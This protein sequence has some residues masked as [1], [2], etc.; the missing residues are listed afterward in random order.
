[1][2]LNK[3][4][5]ISLLFFEV[6][7]ASLRWKFYGW[8]IMEVMECEGASKRNDMEEP[9]DEENQNYEDKKNTFADGD[10]LVMTTT[11]WKFLNDVRGI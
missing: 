2:F 9:K 8:I 11:K 3:I 1:M 10:Y 5:G 4:K 6:L 7:R